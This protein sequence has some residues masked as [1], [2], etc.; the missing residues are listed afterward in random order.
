[1]RWKPQKGYGN[2]RVDQERRPRSVI[3]ITSERVS[4]ILVEQQEEQA[5]SGAT[6]RLL[7][8]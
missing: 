4:E 6:R 7:P 1:M 5:R 8:R 2:G 3:Y